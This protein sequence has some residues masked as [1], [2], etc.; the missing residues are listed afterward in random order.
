LRSIE[1]KRKQKPENDVL[2]ELD[3]EQMLIQAR[4]AAATIPIPVVVGRSRCRRSVEEYRDRSRDT[5]ERVRVLGAE[6]KVGHKFA[7]KSNPK[8]IGRAKN[9]KFDANKGVIIF[10]KINRNYFRFVV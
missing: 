5:T 10:A 9:Q 6:D 1:T 2:E 3:Q 8:K 7:G 4:A